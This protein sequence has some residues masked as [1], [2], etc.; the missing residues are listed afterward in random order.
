MGFVGGVENSNDPL[1][2]V[3]ELVACHSPSVVC[4]IHGVGFVVLDVSGPRLHE[5][6][7]G[8]GHLAFPREYV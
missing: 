7:M 1:I 8:G 5:S 3:L 6:A 2:V 4:L